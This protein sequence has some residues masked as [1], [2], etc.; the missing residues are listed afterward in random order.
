MSS[1]DP[2]SI[3]RV[4]VLRGAASAIYGAEAMG[5][6]INIITRNG[7]NDDG[8]RATGSA[9]AGGQHYGRIG[10]RVS[11]GDA[12]L[13]ISAGVSRLRD[14]SDDAGGRLAL[15]QATAA[16]RWTI[17]PRAQLD[18]DVRHS[19][20]DSTAS[21]TTAAASAWPRCARWNRRKAATT[22]WPRAAAGPS[23]G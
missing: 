12:G 19:D 6:V 18:V 8:T 17:T 23:T 14:G 11:A 4:E 2:A 15:T 22:P 1:L 13:R 9:M 3:E 10:A 7:L 20:R 5:G 21:P 16:A